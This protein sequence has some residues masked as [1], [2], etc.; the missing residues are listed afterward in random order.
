MATCPVTFT[1][2][3][4]G[5]VNLGS[6][7]PQVIFTPSGPTATLDGFL[8]SA[9]PITATLD[10]TTGLGVVELEPY[11]NM[12]D[13]QHYTVRI[14]LLDPNSPST[15]IDFPDWKI[16]VPNGG[17]PLAGMVNA[18]TETN[19]AWVGGP[20]SA[21]ADFRWP[22]SPL[23]GRLN[24]IGGQFTTTLDVS[25]YKLS[26]GAVFYVD[27]VNGL[28]TNAG[29]ISAPYKTIKKAHDQATVQTIMVRATG[30][31]TRALQM[32]GFPITKSL[33]IIG[34]DGTPT[35]ANSDILTW[36]LTSGKTYTYQAARTNVGNVGD[37]AAGLP[38]AMYAKKASIAEVEATPGSYWSD[39]A[40]VY[41]HPIDNRVADA[42][43]LAVIAGGGPILVTIDATIYL[44]GITVLGGQSCIDV[45]APVG[46]VGPILLMKNVRAGFSAVTNVINALGVQ[47]A[48][49]QDCQAFGSVTDGFNYHAYNGIIPKA[50]EINCQGF[51]NGRDT[52][53][54][55]GSTAHDGATVIRVNGRYYDNRHSNVADVHADTQSWN[56]GCTAFSSRGE[57]D[58]AFLTDSPA[59]WLDTCG[60][61][62]S[63]FGLTVGALAT[64][65]VRTSTFDSI[66]GT[67]TAY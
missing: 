17:G 46:G 43:V 12:I 49:S 26:G 60:G 63:R 4:F 28:D 41:V 25:E 8:L 44:E 34:Y 45:R 20:V 16:I 58:W 66:N 32:N 21:P 33:N 35:I 67:T 53:S 47:L 11:A 55:N 3:S 40:L 14:V 15:F 7:M 64:V 23:A 10:P 24:M 65:K 36:T 1:L 54:D 13:P 48:I 31:Y 22:D 51:S 19:P 38:G 30:I 29:T 18:I 27:G 9:A 39:T 6:R 5:R 62:G 56:L 50:I 42:N 52:S 2:A 37:I 61:F 57:D 59:S